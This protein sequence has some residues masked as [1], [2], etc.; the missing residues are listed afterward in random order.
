MITQQALEAADNGAPT[1]HDLLGTSYRTQFKEPSKSVLK[2]NL[3]PAFQLHQMLAWCDLNDDSL[4]IDTLKLLVWCCLGNFCCPIFLVFLSFWN[5]CST[6]K[7]I[8]VF[9]GLFGPHTCHHNFLIYVP[10]C[11]VM[12]VT[13]NV[14]FSSHHD[15]LLPQEKTCDKQ[16]L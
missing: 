5:F 7:N 3:P 1:S 9:S 14:L 8:F 6:N 13:S 4:A 12:G 16:A 11:K 2:W 15:M 10:R